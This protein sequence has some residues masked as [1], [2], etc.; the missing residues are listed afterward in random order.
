MYSDFH[1]H[2]EFSG[3]SDA[4]VRKAIET[5]IALSMKHLC[6]TDHHD[7]DMPAGGL[8]FTLDTDLY[9]NT[10]SALKEEYSSQ[11]ELSIGVELGLQPH[12]KEYLN[13]YTSRYPF[14]FIIGST[15]VVNGI[16]PYFSKFYAGRPEAE[17]YRE[18][19]EQVL[20]NTGRLDCYDVFGHLDYVV[21]YGPDKNKHYSYTVYKE[22]LDEILRTIISKGKGIECNTGGF[23]Y[24]LGHPNPEADLIKRYLE[25][26]GEILTIGSDGHKL[27]EIGYEFPKL[28]ELLKHCGVKYYAV[29]KERIP[30]FF[31]V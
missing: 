13:V 23:K 10:L 27:S 20:S 4:P 22:I 15:H 3:D 2:T 28:T 18:Y 1:V 6:I 21:R 24:G 30:L 26:G 7:Y 19:F 11:I 9:F 5:A 31:P 8:D 16:D 25:L 29:F 14:D 17:A 12:L